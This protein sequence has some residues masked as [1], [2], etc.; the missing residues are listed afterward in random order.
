M[1]GACLTHQSC[2]NS[3][4]A[5]L[6]S[7]VPSQLGN[8]K[9]KSMETLDCLLCGLNGFLE[10]PS[11]EKAVV[12]WDGDDMDPMHWYSNIDILVTDIVVHMVYDFVEYMLGNV[13]VDKAG[14][15]VV[16]SYLQGFGY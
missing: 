16:S 1:R 8:K 4:H 15:Y 14:T 13:D 6:N 5:R 3:T 7:S 11:F 10:G 12:E 9:A 2:L